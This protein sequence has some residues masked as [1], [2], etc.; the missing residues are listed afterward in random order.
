VSEPDPQALRTELLDR[1]ERAAAGW[2]RRAQHI[3]KFG[4][5]VSTWMI[6]HAGLQ[7]GQRV[8]E[9]AA[10]P[11]ET[12][13]LAAELIRPGGV[14]ISSD[15]AE[16]M[17]DIGRAR[18]RELGIE[19]VEFKRL[20]LEWIDLPTA[21]V[22]VVMCRWG[23]MLTV[24]PEAALQ[25]TRRVLVPGGRIVLAVWDQ[26]ES[27][28]WATISDRAMI[29]LGH[30]APPDP[31]SAGP[32]MFSLAAPG[33]LHEMLESAGFVEVLIESVELPRP[34][35]TVQEEIAEK[36]DLSR[37]FADVYDRLS[38]EERRAVEA[39]VA[40]LSEPYAGE[41]GLLVLPARS[42]AATAS[43]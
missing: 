13:F 24:D 15:A 37:A 42:L 12:G 41:D 30:T 31:D 23:V 18:A 17:L 7:P 25:E 2:T 28:P 32:S 9:L 11:G 19:N 10:G 22:D 43:A 38:G 27:N 8:L 29:E 5:P 1:W 4:M 39:K 34:A 40:A 3:R 6:E 35:V 33:R 20:E 26:P 16:A 14:L 36:L 21:S